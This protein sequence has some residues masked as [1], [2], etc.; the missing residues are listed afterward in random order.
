MNVML[1]YVR[2]KVEERYHPDGFNVGI[3]IGE[4]AGQSVFHCHMHLM[5]RYMG[6]VPNPKVGV[7]GFISSKQMY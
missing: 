5:L 3:N 7:R 2:Q 1:Q 6:D 4:A